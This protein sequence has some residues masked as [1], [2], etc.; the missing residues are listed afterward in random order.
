MDRPSWIPVL[1]PRTQRV[2]VAVLLGTLV[3]V[4]WRGSV[5]RRA[6][7]IRS[8]SPVQRAVAFHELASR[9]R[10]PGRAAPLLVSH[11]LGHAH[12]GPWG[13]QHHEHCVRFAR[14]PHEPVCRAWEGQRA[15]AVEVL[16]GSSWRA[17]RRVV[18][19]I[20][21]LA[22]LFPACFET[23]DRVLLEALVHRLDVG[24]AETLVAIRPPAEVMAPLLAPDLEEGSRWER[25]RALGILAALEEPPLRALSGLVETLREVR[26]LGDPCTPW[27]LLGHGAEV[28][29]NLMG[30]L[31]SL[32]TEAA[33][34]VPELLTIVGARPARSPCAIQ[35]SAL[36][37]LVEI[38][39]DDGDV[40]VELVDELARSRTPSRREAIAAAVAA[41]GPRA[42][43]A[44]AALGRTS[45]AGPA[46]VDPASGAR[47][48]ARAT[49][50]R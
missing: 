17:A 10:D 11:L 38:A 44:A 40:V 41:M 31:R 30:L 15:G 46:L 9:S 49:S 29:A 5:D 8:V 36:E 37:A 12:Q 34:A 28:D 50:V 27:G 32:G 1:E 19:G 42:R 6:L 45:G 25:V 33:P 24:S 21:E 3:W 23:E 48:A 22:E 4:G 26:T 43:D 14:F 7:E 13:A 2:V 18:H 16:R 20:G 35:R 47:P 39:P